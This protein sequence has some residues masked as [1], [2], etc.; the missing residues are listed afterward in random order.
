MSQE[1]RWLLFFVIM[2]HL[3]SRS[4]VLSSG[5][6]YKGYPIFTVGISYTEILKVPTFSL[7]TSLVSR[8]RISV[9]LSGLRI[10]R[11]TCGSL[12]TTQ[13]CFIGMLGGNK[14]AH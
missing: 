9:S 14:A 7:T 13:P 8:Y 10:V 6:S 11:P 1:A 3:R 4:F 12:T 2:E 5:K